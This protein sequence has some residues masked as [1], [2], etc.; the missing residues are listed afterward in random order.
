MRSYDIYNVKEQYHAYMIGREKL[1]Y[2]L[3]KEDEQENTLQ[4]VHYLCER[5]E[6]AAIEDAVI[7]N[8]GKGF[9]S[10]EQGDKKFKLTHPVKGSIVISVSSYALTVVCDGS[11][12]LDLDLF[13]AL[14]GMN[15]RFF[16]VMDGYGE[17]GWL[18]PVKYTNLRVSRENVAFY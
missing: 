10:I 6:G 16:A 11:R 1:L 8:L 13:V 12:M 4:E 7:T 18:K 17:W 5:L 3:L 2:E 15:D 9:A 14:S